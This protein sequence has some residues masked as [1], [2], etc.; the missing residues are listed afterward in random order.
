MVAPINKM[1][2]RTKKSH[3]VHILCGLLVATVLSALIQPSGAQVVMEKLLCDA[4][5]SRN[6][7]RLCTGYKNDEPCPHN[8]DPGSTHMCAS[9]YAAYR[10]MVGTRN[11]RRLKSQTSLFQLN[12]DPKRLEKKLRELVA[13]GM[14][15]KV[16]PTRRRL[17][18][19]LKST[20]KQVAKMEL[21]SKAL[22]ATLAGGKAVVA[23]GKA[24]VEGVVSLTQ[25]G[26]KAFF[27]ILPQGMLMFEKW[28]FKEDKLSP[29][30]AQTNKEEGY[31][32]CMETFGDNPL[33]AQS[34]CVNPWK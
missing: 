18:S 12:V 23:G 33:L 6:G 31:K 16:K 24:A 34:E 11:G 13:A 8:A 7:R 10:D 29:K 26:I 17:P 3:T 14:A 32:A 4:E 9:C 5:A 28:L 30:D 1:T 27:V 25:A 2:I 21:P 22:G 15:K 20:I 19:A